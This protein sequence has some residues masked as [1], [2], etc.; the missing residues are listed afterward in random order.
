M[1]LWSVA[2]VSCALA[3]SACMPHKIPGTDID[4]T[5]DTRAVLD[6]VNRYRQ[7]VEQRNT[8][9]IIDLADESFRD[10]GGS[11][12]PEDDLDYKSLYTVLPGRFQ[13]VDEVHLD[14]NVR[15]IEFDEGQKLARVTYTYTMSFKMPSISDR[16]QTESDI[17]QMTLTRV[18]DK[19]WRITS[20]I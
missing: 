14:V 3:L 4:D 17:K 1:R 10:D 6:V 13:K 8:Q 7:A 5:S 20:G 2:L 18:G 19:D 9:A 15:K 16:S 11:S 12:T